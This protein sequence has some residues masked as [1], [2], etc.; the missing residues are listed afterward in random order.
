[1]LKIFRHFYAIN[2][3]DCDYSFSWLN[4]TQIQPDIVQS[5]HCTVTDG[6]IQAGRQK[7]MEFV[8]V[9][10]CPGTFEY[11]W[12]FCIP[13]HDIEMVF[14]FVIMAQEPVMYF[15]SN[16]LIMPPTSVGATVTGSVTLVNEDDISSDFFFQSE[17]LYSEGRLNSLKVQPMSGKIGPKTEMS[18]KISFTGKTGGKMLFQL[19]CKLKKLQNPII[20]SVQ[21]MTYTVEPLITFV[22]LAGVKHVA[23]PCK[24]TEGNIVDF[25]TEVC[26]YLF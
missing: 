21:T 6:T 22:D 24:C 19:K 13:Q 10:Q 15:L 7:L 18:F 11:F 9:S 16:N 20:I 14:L 2:P 4:V 23:K 26:L 25:G 17:S 8:F 12:K 3:T 5:L 1:M